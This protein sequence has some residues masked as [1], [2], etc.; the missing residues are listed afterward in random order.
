MVLKL[1][2]TGND[3]FDMKLGGGIPYP[4]LIVIEG[5][6][7]SGKTALSLLFLKGALDAG[8][9]AIVFTSESKPFDYI[10]KAEASG[11]PLENHYLERKL[12]IYSM[13]YPGPLTKELADTI[14]ER[15]SHAVKKL[16]DHY[17]FLVI[18]SIT[19][20][21]ASATPAL[22][23]TLF[24]QL[25]SLVVYNKGVIITSHPGIVPEEAR[26]RLAGSADGY[27]KTSAAVIGGRRLKVLSVVK[28]RGAPPGI[29]TTIT[30]D[31]DPAFGIKLVPIMVSQA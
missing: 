8:Y 15:L 23:N 17:D 18:D 9:R 21:A 3:E 2:P 24:V 20:L 14:V 4:A 27:L 25:K 1:L 29:D 22:L 28:L 30:F 11:F 10:I 5:E 19:Y 12:R 16:S 7:G 31:V 13:Q 6:H 26:V